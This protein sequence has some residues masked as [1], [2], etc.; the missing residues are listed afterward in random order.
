M[1]KQ[2]IAVVDDDK[3]LVEATLSLMESVGFNAKGF[4]SAEDFLNSPLRQRIDCLILD[5]RMP[6]MGGLELQRLL[7]A[8]NETVPIIF[9]TA[10]AAEDVSSKAL[11]AG[12]VAFLLKP[13]SQ[14]S[15][16]RAVRSALTNP[17]NR[18]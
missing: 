11:K 6:Q 5:V 9:M 13:F 2:L 4:Y 3:S 15:L 10:H 16:L 18:K 14:E 12:A 8:R 1:E 7:A 17:G